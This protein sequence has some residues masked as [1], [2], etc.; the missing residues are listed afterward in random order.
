MRTTVTSDGKGEATG[1]RPKVTSGGKILVAIALAAGAGTTLYWLSFSGAAA[2]GPV[3]PSAALASLLALAA[4]TLAN[5]VLRWLRWHFL[6]RRLGVRYRARPSLRLYFATLPLLASPFFIGEIARAFFLPVDERRARRAI[7]Q[8]WVVERLGDALALGALWL[9]AE[10]PGRTPAWLVAY[11]LC[12]FVVVRLFATPAGPRGT[13]P[14]AAALSA[15]TLVTWSLPCLG[16]G[17]AMRL[18]GGAGG[19]LGGASV[20]AESTLL[21][22]ASGI[23]LGISATGSIAAAALVAR[24]VPHAAL[25]ALIMRLG[26]V[27]FALTLGALAFLALARRGLGRDLVDRASASHFDDLAPEYEDEIP[28]HVRRHLVA[29]K[30]ELM[31]HRLGARPAGGRLAGLDVGCG[32]ARYAI[33]LAEQGVEM[34]GVDASPGQ[35]ARAEANARAAGAT[36]RLVGASGARLPF[37]D[38]SFDFAYAINVVHHVLDEAE[39]AKMLEEIVRVLRP[40][41]C[42]FLHEMNTRNPVFSFYMSYVFPLRRRI[43]EGN[44]VWVDPRAL[45]AVQG[46]SWDPRVDYFTF[47]P[48]FT[49]PAWL[50]SLARL[51]RWLERSRARTLSAHFVAVLRKPAPETKAR[52]AGGAPA[53]SGDPVRAVPEGAGAPR[54]ER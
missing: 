51:E 30:L 37:A 33:A 47:L 32:P 13:F 45:P 25:I 20:F 17:L 44:E 24:G 49:P 36:V 14:A 11:F 28:E 6:A 54:R 46:G 8:T 16:V 5:L 27:W 10:S 39:R 34:T 42:F 1:L 2:V 26:T 4:L 48:D 7:F 52:S 35:L 21:G 38:D 23:P 15:L 18:V 40:G 31:L 19:W 22:G 53:A 9:T 50:P 29:R 41:G 12:V 43:D 3:P